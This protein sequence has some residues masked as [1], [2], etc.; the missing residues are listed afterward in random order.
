ML[1]ERTQDSSVPVEK[2]EKA[3]ETSKKLVEKIA[4]ACAEQSAKAAAAA[5]INQ[6][7]PPASPEARPDVELDPVSL[8]AKAKA[9]KA[10]KPIKKES[11]PEK[12]LPKTERGQKI[13]ELILG[14]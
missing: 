7:V 3:A 9:V 13:K 12:Y 11:E 8:E 14:K 6:P 2:R 4:K 10:Q 5:K 1:N